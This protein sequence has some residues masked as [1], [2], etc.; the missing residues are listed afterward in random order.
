MQVEIKVKKVYGNAY[1]TK[2]L[3]ERLFLRAEWVKRYFE[4]DTFNTITVCFS[5]EPHID[6]YFFRVTRQY[7]VDAA[8][9]YQ[10]DSVKS[11]VLCEPFVYPKLYDFVI[12]HF[13]SGRA[14]IS[15]Y[16]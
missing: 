10:G 11:S 15:I 8:V 13:P 3:H 12:E 16:V 4:V 7:G 1:S 5:D 6:S 2:D 9:V 14:F